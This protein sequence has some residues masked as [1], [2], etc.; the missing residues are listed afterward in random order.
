LNAGR[1]TLKQLQVFTAVVDKGSLG[2]AAGQL[3]ISKAAVSMAL[4]QLESRLGEPLFD[5]LSNRL[6]INARGRQLLPMALELQQRCADIEDLF[7]DSELAGDLIIGC[8]HTIGS[9]LLPQLLADFSQHQSLRSQR[10]SIQ[11]SVELADALERFELDV[12]FIEADIRRT[13]LQRQ[14][15]LQDEMAVVCHPGHRLATTAVK[16]MSELEGQCWV[17]RERGSGTRRQ[18]DECLAASLNDYQVTLES[19]NNEAVLS[20]VAAG[21]GLGFLSNISTQHAVASGRLVELAL[22]QKFQRQL[23]LLYHQDK[24]QS[25]VV[26]R[27]IHF[28]DAWQG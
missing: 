7:D 5:R 23:Y 6:K 13:G 21:I 19:D 15:W 28:A 24:Y 8:S 26:Q 17:L 25:P 12:A 10:L 14:A 3:F 20:A 16:S 18:F 2:R 22:N 27:F 9:G 11:N 1:L 4:Q